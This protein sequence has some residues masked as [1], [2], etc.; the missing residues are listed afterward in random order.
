MNSN[1]F[2][3]YTND[4]AQYGEDLLGPHGTSP[5]K[6]IRPTRIYPPGHG[7]SRESPRLRPTDIHKWLGRILI[8]SIESKSSDPQKTL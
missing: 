1:S 2:G 4:F 8:K 6:A 5:P 7:D 3:A